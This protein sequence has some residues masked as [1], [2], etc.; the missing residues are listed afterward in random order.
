MAESKALIAV[1]K[2]VPADIFKSGGMDPVL[3]EIEREAKA[4]VPDLT[5]VKG[6]KAIASNAAKVA[7]SK[8]FLDK[9]GKTL[10]D[11]YKA[12]IDPIDGER[13]KT[14]EFL[15]ALKIEVRKPL[16]DWEAAEKTRKEEEAK[17]AE[18]VQ[19]W[20]DAH[21]ENELFDRERDIRL[22]EEEM[23]RK[24]AQE[25]ERLQ[26]IEA[27][28][29]AKE[30]A[31][32]KAKVKAEYEA[33]LKEEAA[34]KAKRE[35]EE[36][37]EAEK[38][39]VKF[40]ADFDTAI[41]MNQTFNLEMEKI[42]A[43]D[44][45]DREARELIDKTGRARVEILSGIG[46]T[47]DFE[48]CRDMTEEAWIEFSDIKNAEYQKKKNDIW[49]EN[50][51]KKIEEAAR[52]AE[53]DRIGVALRAKEKRIADIKAAEEKAAIEAARVAAEKQAEIDLLQ[54]IERE[55]VAEENRRLAEQKRRDEDK[56]HRRG[57]NARILEALMEY[58]ECSVEGGQAFVE[59]VVLGKVDNIKI[60]Y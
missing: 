1:E 38:A 36:K 3:A 10:K 21:S 32:L 57:I 6:R 47:L 55:R 53:Q 4:L 17:A 33:K 9:M 43:K 29:V 60:T 56:A 8:T 28:R 41:A 18:Y 58:S 14:R 48:T 5:T 20:D 44:R 25:T 31:E 15:D 22:K 7:S 23:A 46:V 37:A 50:Q 51:R 52:K 42:A 24:E 49:I 39:L 45:S 59:A 16:T 12:I 27:E 35:A 2:L 34:A 30:Q 40:N 13:R 11:G 26:A 19:A 54:R